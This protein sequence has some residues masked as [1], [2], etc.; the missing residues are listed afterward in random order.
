MISDDMSMLVTNDNL[1]TVMMSALLALA[2]IAAAEDEGV[3]TDPFDVG[4][5]AYNRGDLTGALASFE[6]AAEAGSDE[7]QV[8]MGY[9]LDYSEQNE[10]SVRWYRAAA[11]QGNLDGVA[12]LAEMHAKGEG[13]EQNFDKALELYRQAG[14]S[15][16]AASI[17][18]L[19]AAYANGGLGLDQDVEQIAYWKARQAELPQTEDDGS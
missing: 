16:H 1:R 7:A 10:E 15:G 12:G 3:A 9:L 5:A 2:P 8:W 17:R 4:M 6:E 19:I 11:A 13:V 18:V 14:E